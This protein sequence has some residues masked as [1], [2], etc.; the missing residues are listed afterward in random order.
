MVDGAPLICAHCRRPVTGRFEIKRFDRDGS[1]RGTVNVCS[2]VCLAQW[3][4]GAAVT[5]GVA[6]AIGIKDAITNIIGVLR[7]PRRS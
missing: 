7:G 4:Y 5:H 1:E 3:A 2:L 6:G